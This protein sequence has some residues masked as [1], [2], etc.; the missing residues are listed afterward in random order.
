MAGVLCLDPGPFTFRSLLTMF[1]ANQRTQWDH[2]AA[3][4]A[5]HCTSRVA[6]PY[7]KKRGEYGSRS[8]EREYDRLV[9]RQKGKLAA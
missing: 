4:I 5:P 7:R 6:N 2:T 1:T 9:A 3:M 8:I